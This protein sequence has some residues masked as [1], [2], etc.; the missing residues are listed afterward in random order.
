[1]LHPVVE[2]AGAGEL[3]VWAEASESRRA[4]MA[5][6]ATLLG[7][8]AEALGL[9][10]EERARWRALGCLHDAL[11]NADPDALRQRVPPTFASLPGPLLHGP[12]AAE[13]LRIDGV[14]DGA[15]MR[16]VAYHTVG[17]ADLDRLGRALYA[18]DFLDPGRDLLNDWR[19][20]LRT[21][22]PGDFDEVVREI[23]GARIVYLIEQTST[24]RAETASFWNA[25][26]A[27][28]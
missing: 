4:H 5:R 8:W 24:L 23:L 3:P 14:E 21:R 16:A 20:N 27:E 15:F 7:S 11:R 25:L 9:P 6:V 12:A 18:A 2:R 28:A 22:M 13:R 17:H 26:V 10:A 19:A 1:M